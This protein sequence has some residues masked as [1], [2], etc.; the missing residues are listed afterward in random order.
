[1][2]PEQRGVEAYA[3]TYRSD[4]DFERLARKLR[5]SLGIDDQLRPDM[6]D[7]LIKLK[8]HGYIP[9]LVRVPD[10]YMPGVEAKFDPC[11]RKLY[12][13][14]STYVA[15]EKG[16]PRARWTASHEVGHIALDHQRARNRSSLPTMIERIAPTIRRDETEANKF[17]AAFLAPFHITDFSLETTAEEIAERFGISLPA[18]TRR[19][20]EFARMYR[21]LHRIRRPLP[22]GIIDFLTEARRKGNN[23]RSLDSAEPIRERIESEHYEGDLCPTCYNFRMVR[24]GTFLI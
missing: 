17:A 6:I 24:N 14:E 4:E 16:E 10:E 5:V 11:D 15:M 7:V 1:M 23:V 19:I 3:M 13:T 18:A 20:E 2:P 8:H 22:V 12:V 9:D 21:Q